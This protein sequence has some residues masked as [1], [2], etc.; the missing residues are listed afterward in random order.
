MEQ[1]PEIYFTKL[2]VAAQLLDGE[3]GYEAAQKQKNISADDLVEML[4]LGGKYLMKRGEV[5]KARSQFLIAQGVI[6]AFAHDFLETKWFK[7]TVYESMA[8]K[9]EEI[10]RLLEDLDSTNL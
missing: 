1:I 3:E 7:R 5:E 6:E 8:E 10:A 4:L 2:G 9:R